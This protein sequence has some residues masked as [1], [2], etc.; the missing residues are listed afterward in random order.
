MN[1]RI[2]RFRAWDKKNKRFISPFFVRIT[3]FGKIWILSENLDYVLDDENNVEIT[4]FTGLC[5]KNG[6]EIYEGD[7]IK[8][9]TKKIEEIVWIKCHDL[10]DTKAYFDLEANQCWDNGNSYEDYDDRWERNENIAVIG[11]IYEN[12]ELLNEEAI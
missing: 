12:P 2:Y 5:D 10:T 9:R 8:I 3:G 11:N 1:N 7:I 4:Q 6:K